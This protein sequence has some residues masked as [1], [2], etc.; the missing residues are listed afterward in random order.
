M[1]TIQILLSLII[2]AGINISCSNNQEKSTDVSIS[3]TDIVK[4]Y[5]FH[6]EH[7]CTTCRTVEAERRQPVLT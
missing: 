7:R 3:N 5:Y 6:N 4:V 1:K 2:I